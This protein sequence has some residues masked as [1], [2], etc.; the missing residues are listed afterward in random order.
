MTPDPVPSPVPSRPPPL[1]RIVTTA[2]ATFSTAAMTALDSSMR[3][4]LTLSAVGDSVIEPPVG[5]AGS[6]TRFEIATAESAPDRMPANTARPMTGRAD[7]PRRGGADAGACDERVLQAP[8]T[9]PVDGPGS[10]ETTGP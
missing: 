7:R 1:D 5:T 4:S 6:R 10:R 8:A 3:T 2:G 9:C